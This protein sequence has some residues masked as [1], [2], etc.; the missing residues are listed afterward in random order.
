M[1]G[2]FLNGYL[3]E[4][5]GSFALF[6]ISSLIALSGGLIFWGFCLVDRKRLG[7]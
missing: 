3:Y 4:I 5:T 6:M 2:F 1:V 7:N